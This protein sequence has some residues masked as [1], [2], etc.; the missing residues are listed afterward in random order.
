[1]SS[2]LNENRNI[3]ITDIYPFPRNYWLILPPW[4][5]KYNQNKV[6]FYISTVIR[7]NASRYSANTNNGLSF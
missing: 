4:N 3:S 5:V 2:H 6:Y 7:G 1:M